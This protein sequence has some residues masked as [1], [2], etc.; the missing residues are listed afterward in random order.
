MKVLWI[1]N[2][3]ELSGYSEASRNYIL[4]LDKVGVDVVPRYF[5]L[6][7]PI[8]DLPKRLLE[9]EEKSEEG[10]DVCV[11]H[12]LPYYMVKDGRFRKNVGLFAW[13]TS[14]INETW[15]RNLNLMDEVWV[16]CRQQDDAVW[17]SGLKSPVSIVNHCFDINKYFNKHKSDNPFFKELNNR[18]T[19]KFYSIGEWTRRK[20]FAALVKA[21]HLEFQPNEPVDL[22]IKTGKPG[23][24]PE[25]LK[26]EVEAFCNEM[27]KGLKL[28]GHNLSPYKQE[29]II[30]GNMTDEDINCLHMSCDCFVQPSYGEAWSQPAFD[31]M[32]FCKRPIVTEG[33]GYDD[34]IDW[35]VGSFISSREE[36]VFGMMDTFPDLYTGYEDWL[37][38]DI[39]DLQRL[40]RL[41]YDMGTKKINNL[42]YQQTPEKV[43]NILGCFSYE[44]IGNQM[45]SLLEA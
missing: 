5:Q 34:Y 28:Y 27:K 14:K 3:K 18:P 41:E 33:T 30:T 6:G 29:I 25:H 35:E 23:I 32:G 11:Q 36:P 16:V 21:F 1:S 2:W 26:N 22:V 24:H 4:A 20:N 13:E 31:A 8:S 9:L 40:M 38:V 7:Q 43:S 42:L 37:S 15:L 44:V 19:F 45:K 17:N 10:C 39:R 12:T